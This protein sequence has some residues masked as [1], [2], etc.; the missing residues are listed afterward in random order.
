MTLNPHKE[1]AAEKVIRAIDYEHPLFDSKTILAQKRIPEIQGRG[2][3]YYAGAWQ[4][5]GFH[6]DGLK[7]GL[8]VARLLNLK[9]PWSPVYE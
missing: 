1:I 7:A 5:Y 9:I 6:E 2:G 3:V 8:R 4:G